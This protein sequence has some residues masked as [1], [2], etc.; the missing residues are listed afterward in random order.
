MFQNT[1][2]LTSRASSPSRTSLVKGVI[3]D[4]LAAA[5]DA[6]GDALEF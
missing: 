2:M 5:V 1:P 3:T 4:R 6:E